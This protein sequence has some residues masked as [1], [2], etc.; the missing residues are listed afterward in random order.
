MGAHRAR[1]ETR[2]QCSKMESTIAAMKRENESLRQTIATLEERVS[3][4][5]TA[6]ASAIHAQQDS[7]HKA[8]EAEVEAARRGE[9]VMKERERATAAEAEIESCQ[10]AERKAPP[11]AEIAEWLRSRLRQLCSWRQRQNI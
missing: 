3:L 10:L 7:A 4:A 11:R 5:E 2:L 8:Q 6:R 9:E 1:T